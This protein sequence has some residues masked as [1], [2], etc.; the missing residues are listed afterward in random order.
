MIDPTSNLNDQKAHLIGAFLD[1]LYGNTKRHSQLL[2][3]AGLKR[4]REDARETPRSGKKTENLPDRSKGKSGIIA[5]GVALAAVLLI[6]VTV[7]IFDT[8]QTA[9]AAVDASIAQS[10][11]KIGRHYSITT[12]LRLSKTKTVDR[13]VDLFVKGANHVVM[14]AESL[15]SGRPIW[16]GN[17]QGAAW[18]VPP[19]G[20]VIVGNPGNLTQW[21]IGQ[22]EIGTPYLH[23][24]TILTRMRDF[25]QLESLPDQWIKIDNQSVRCRHITGKLNSEG[26]VHRPDIIELWSDLES[27]FAVQLIARWHLSDGEVGRESVEVQFQEPVE[28]HDQF[29]TPDA[30]GG[31]DRP[32]VDFSD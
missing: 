11:Q 14:R 32:R 3:T 31:K 21:V 26:S 29:F 12:K 10:L 23:L 28:L 9:V 16:I 20:P 6:A 19:R 7:R 17:D 18:V 2:V 27:G 1:A 4:L 5:W 13:N 22:E 15:L 25:Y 30:H 24:S 8:S